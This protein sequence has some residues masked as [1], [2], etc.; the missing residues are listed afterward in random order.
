MATVERIDL[1]PASPPERLPF[2]AVWVVLGK[3]SPRETKEPRSRVFRD[4]LLKWLDWRSL[5]QLGRAAERTGDAPTYVAL[6]ADMPV[7]WLVVDRS[8][9]VDA[10]AL[11]RA[12]RELGLERMLVVAED[13]AG[14]ERCADALAQAP[15]ARECDAVYVAVLG[16]TPE[17]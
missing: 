15:G 7:R 10:E 1:D 9:P 11:Y 2:D 5:G 17:R 8:A 4:E 16:G 12:C 6:G 13:V 3:E 14:R